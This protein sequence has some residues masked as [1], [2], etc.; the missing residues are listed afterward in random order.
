MKTT[1]LRKIS[2]PFFLIII[3]IG[4][5]ITIT[6]RNFIK[7]IDTINSIENETDKRSFLDNVRHNISKSLMYANDYI[8]TENKNYIIKYNES[9]ELINNNMSILVGLNLTDEERQIIIELSAD[10]DSMNH[11]AD[12]ILTNT[13]PKLSPDSPMVME[14]MD[15]RFGEAAY[16][17]I[18]ILYKI[19]FYR[20]SN[21]F[22]L[23][24]NFKETALRDIYFLSAVAIILSVLVTLLT[25]KRISKPLRSL[26]E[27]SKSIAG[28]NYENL[29]V[30][31]SHDEIAE[32][33]K[34]ITDIAVSI[35]KS[36][37]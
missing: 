24:K 19:I 29:P 31:N 18:D 12:L 6:Y 26:I 5:M 30:V 35:K 20:I 32:L 37:Q 10:L 22:N 27:T 7:T 34:A 3:L 33:S 13:N 11:Y 2:F 9:S 4:L 23:I 17:K 16:N 15:Y 25:A 28:G 36:N 21:E 14:I 8:I 1:I